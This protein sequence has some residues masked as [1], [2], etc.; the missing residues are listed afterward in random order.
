MTR[1]KNAAHKALST[2]PPGGAIGRRELNPREEP[3]R[4]VLPQ[5]LTL[6]STVGFT[7]GC[8][9]E[10]GETQAKKPCVTVT[11]EARVWSKGKGTVR[12]S[13]SLRSSWAP[14]KQ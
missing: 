2:P 10:R 9:R 6:T 14:K 5:P 4:S 11:Q 13:G 7:S 3:G 12:D 8:Q 1:A